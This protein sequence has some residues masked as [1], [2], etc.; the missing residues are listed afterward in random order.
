[1][2]YLIIQRGIEHQ[3]PIGYVDKY[4]EAKRIVQV[5]NEKAPKKEVDGKFYPQYLFCE[6]DNFFEIFNKITEEV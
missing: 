4:E 1:M 3:H 5:M 6:L 2:I